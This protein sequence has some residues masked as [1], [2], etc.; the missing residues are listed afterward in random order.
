MCSITYILRVPLN[1][2][3]KLAIGEFL[4][5]IIYKMAFFELLMVKVLHKI[6]LIIHYRRKLT[7]NKMYMCICTKDVF[8]VVKIV[9]QYQHHHQCH[10]H[11]SLSS[12]NQ[13]L[14]SCRTLWSML[15]HV[16]CRYIS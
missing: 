5:I 14:Y 1:L 3:R 9:H 6:F 4:S 2:M 11:L 10:L 16:F 13:T 12:Y 15:Y 7:K 8:I